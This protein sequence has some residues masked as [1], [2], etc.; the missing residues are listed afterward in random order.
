M[1]DIK[2]DVKFTEQFY[3]CADLTSTLSIVKDNTEWNKTA[4]V[5]KTKWLYNINVI[6]LQAKQ[7]R[8]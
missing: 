7:N 4:A 2:Y 6:Q 1:A 5:Q 3:F 8:L